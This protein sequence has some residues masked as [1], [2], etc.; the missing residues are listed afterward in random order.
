VKRRDGCVSVN[1]VHGF[2]H[3][4]LRSDHFL[5]TLRGVRLPPQ[6][7]KAAQDES[8]KQLQE[9]ASRIN[10]DVRVWLTGFKGLLDTVAR[11]RGG[12]ISENKALD[13]ALGP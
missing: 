8:I 6:T 9:T 4:E 1:F 10:R 11:E 5:F 12:R 2:R 3:I 13:E 7:V